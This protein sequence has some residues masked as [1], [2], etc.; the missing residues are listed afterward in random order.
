MKK[1]ILVTG[2][3]GF[4]GNYVINELLR[5]DVII[6]ATSSN[7]EKARRQGWYPKVK[8]IPFDFSDYNSGHNY[9]L[10]FDRPDILIHLGW[11]GLPNYKSEFHIKEN[12]PRHKLFL[13][14]LIRNGLINLTVT[15]TCLEYGMQQGCLNEDMPTLPSTPYAIAK[16]LLRQYLE[17]L[18]QQ[19]SFSLKWLRLFY[20]Y[21]KGQN[22]NSILSQLE[23]AVKKGEKTF[24]MSGGEQTRDYLHVSKVAEIIVSIALQNAVSEIINCCSGAPVSIKEFVEMYLKKTGDAIQLNLGF[25]PYPDY[26]PMHFWGSTEKLNKALSEK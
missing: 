20:M 25:Y 23:M 10:F 14:N 9:F 24:N 4:V 3:T 15:G 19:H 21:G 12:L 1:R 6:I 22:A 26:E 18:Q 16:D 5:H 17:Q 11:E 8:Y 7:E 2:A 13:E